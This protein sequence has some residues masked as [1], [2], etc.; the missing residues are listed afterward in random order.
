[1]G[2]RHTKGVVAGN[3]PTD[4]EET[5]I[6]GHIPDVEEAVLFQRPDLCASASDFSRVLEAAPLGDRSA[7]RRPVTDQQ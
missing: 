6:D 2:A 4:D 7:R 3:Q 5:M 1:M